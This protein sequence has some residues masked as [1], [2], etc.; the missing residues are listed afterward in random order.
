MHRDLKLDNLIL[1]RKEDMASSKIID[2]GL[3][4]FID[5]EEFLLQKCGSPSYIAPEVFTGDVYD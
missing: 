1:M 4:Q 3:A 5:E 2:F